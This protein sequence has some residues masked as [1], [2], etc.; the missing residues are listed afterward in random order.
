VRPGDIVHV[1]G[2][3]EQI[4]AFMAA[5]TAEVGAGDGGG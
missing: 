2:L 5:A 3:P 1:F 4:A